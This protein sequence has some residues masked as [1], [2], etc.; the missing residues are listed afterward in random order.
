[1][2]EDGVQLTAHSGVGDSISE[3]TLVE[4]T[5]FTDT[6]TE[7]D[8]DHQMLNKKLEEPVEKDNAEPAG[9]SGVSKGKKI[10]LKKELNLL[11]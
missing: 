7:D 4:E 8:S 1:M 9:T 6:E 2:E 10:G 11:L 3:S 5:P